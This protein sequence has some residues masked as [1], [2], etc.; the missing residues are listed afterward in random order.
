[1][2]KAIEIY[3]LFVGR[4]FPICLLLMIFPVQMFSKT[5]SGNSQDTIRQ[6]KVNKVYKSVYAGKPKDHNSFYKEMWGEH[7]LPLYYQPVR[8]S[9][10]TLNSVYGGLRKVKQVPEFYG[11]L[12]EDNKNQ[13]YLLK[14]LG[15]VNSFSESKFF[16]SIY[17]PQDFKDT[18]LGDFIREAYTIQHPYTFMVSDYLAKASGLYSGNPEIYHISPSDTDTITDGTEL[19]DKL[20]S[21][22]ELPDITSQRVITNAEVLIKKI[23]SNNKYTIDRE[24]YIRSR[25][26]DMLI[27]DW[28]KIPEN[29]NWISGA[30]E[31]STLYRP[32]VLDRSYAF[33]KV[34]GWALRKLLN[35]LGLG[36]VTDYD[37]EIK[38]LKKINK[39]GYELDVALTSGCEK[40]MWIDQANFLNNELTD[41]VIDEA[42]YH[43]PEEMQG[44]NVFSIKNKLKNRRR[45]LV[46]SAGEYYR[47]L[48]KTP[49]VTG[50]DNDERFE[51]ERLS[52]KDVEIR[53][54]NAAND[55]L[56]FD[57][58][59][60]KDLTKEIWIYGLDGHDKFQVKGDG[61]GIP[62][63]LIGGKGTNKYDIHSNK[64]LTIYEGQQQKQYLDSM[65]ITP[66]VKLI[67]PSDE[68]ALEYDYKKLI[69]T[70]FN[71]TP[72]GVYDSDLGLDIGTSVAYTIYGFRRAPFSRQHQLSYSYN[73]GFVYQ[74]I[75]PDFNSKK[76]IHISAFMSSPN[77]FINFFGFGNETSRD[78]DKDNSYNRVFLNK[79][80]LTPA[81][82]YTIDKDQEF[83]ISA[84]F[85]SY[86]P[87]NPDG[88]NRFINEIYEDNNSIFDT[89]FYA[90]INATYV[91]D[92]KM[93]GLV[94]SFKF[95]VNPGWVVNLGDMKNNFPYIKSDL[96]VN[97][98]FTDHI[99]FAT[100][101]KGTTLLTDKYEF[102]QAATTELRGFR[103]NRFIGRHSFYQYTDIRLDMGRL[104]N[105]FTPLDYGVFLGFDNGR[106]WY[107]GENSKKWHTSYGGGLW[108]TVFKNF[109]GKFSYFASK[110]DGRFMFELGLVF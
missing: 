65:S 29:W 5:L 84:S 82:Y 83:N 86:K 88:R 59:F 107:T 24:L 25:L 14:P 42:F 8:V 18:Y 75:F 49:V 91:I 56:I 22:Y 74:G 41:K 15:G 70:E 80:A 47:M 105:P 78:K 55:S 21:I 7:Y 108:L 35:M 66:D 45:Y 30:N 44:N 101:L 92:K 13:Y 61:G 9:T 104:E 99:I 103:D 89:K 71:V 57:K 53:V 58:K 76:R 16:Q 64:K 3:K 110:D 32:A 2:D 12:L 48:Q 93:D 28:N 43:L 26:F 23:Q 10:I 109:T 96:G 106:V 77:Y 33:T 34:D 81:I 94:S 37:S 79:Y 87:D 68:K 95:L 98:K 46:K 4:C 62:I 50:T 100:L 20:V 69:Y 6:A 11:L 40:S 67:V 52:P 1:M 19:K 102:Y 38:D 73:S 36:F 31:D 17:N 72:I 85:E 63:L 60:T 27:G 39:L 51:I 90:D 54:Y 97:L